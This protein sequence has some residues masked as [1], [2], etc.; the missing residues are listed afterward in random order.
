VPK[1]DEMGMDYLPVYQEQ[2]SASSQ[3]QLSPEKIQK[4]GVTTATVTKRALIR[5]IRALGTIQIDERRVQVVAPKVEGWIQQLYVNA[6]GQA[7][8]KGQALLEIYSPDF[9]AAQQDYLIARKG[10]EAMQKASPQ[11]RENAAQLLANTLQRLRYWDIDPLTLKLLKQR[12]Q[13]LPTL[14]L[15]APM[16]GVVIE[17]PAQQGM[18][19]M[20]GELLFRIAD[21]NQVWLLADVFEQ[22]LSF[23]S[24]G[25]AVQVYISAFPERLFAGKV[26]FIYPNLSQETRTVKVRIE[27][28]NQNGLLKPGLY[29][30]VTLATEA[31]KSATLAAP[32]SA[33]I[34]TGA[35]QIA[36][37]KRSEGRFEARTVKLGALAEGYYE[38]L[39]GLSEGD[40][41]VTHANFL[42]DAESKLKSALENFSSLADEPAQTP[43]GSANAEQGVH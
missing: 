37:L 17:K 27:L 18:R 19:F 23:L 29:A 43:A 5:R 6:T 3:L 40:Q 30:S 35:R 9:L 26:S 41:V 38:I 2:V 32:E 33:I 34:D 7:V 15:L 13:A 16:T 25:Q 14:P 10:Q 21:L 11:A 8:K 42:I 39:K 24:L 12:D 22:D 31:K 1:K 28:P 20:P 4:L 36:L